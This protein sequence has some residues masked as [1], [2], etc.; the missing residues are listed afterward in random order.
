MDILPRSICLDVN[1]IDG[2]I[3]DISIPSVYVVSS[4]PLLPSF[5][6]TP[7]NT[8]P[9]IESFRG[10]ISNVLA[11]FLRS[12]LFH[13]H[14][15]N[16]VFFLAPTVPRFFFSCLCPSR[17]QK[18]NVISPACVISTTLW[19]LASKRDRRSLPSS[20]SLSLSST[21]RPCRVFLFLRSDRCASVYLVYLSARLVKRA[22]LLMVL[23]ISLHRFRM[24]LW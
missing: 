6:A 12:F 24:F 13:V 19:A 23:E 22:P 15:F 20:L 3:P 4:L 8:T 17:G 21:I 9:F 14:L 11:S 5:L 18:E 1:A 7:P 10:K 2:S 16:E